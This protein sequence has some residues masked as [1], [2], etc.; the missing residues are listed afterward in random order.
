MSGPEFL[1]LAG[2]ALFSAAGQ[3]LLRRAAGSWNT[4]AGI[5]A[6]VRSFLRSTAIPALVLVLGAPV[7]YWKALETVPLSR[8]YAMTALTGVLVQIGGGLLLNEKPNRRSITGAL[9]CC[10]GIALWGL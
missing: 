3:M 7:L 2:V 9:L 4:R 8:A 1:M 6:F 10:A 5:T